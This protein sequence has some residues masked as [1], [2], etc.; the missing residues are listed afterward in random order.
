MPQSSPV[1]LFRS[2]LSGREPPTYSHHS[3]PGKPISVT[4]A[5]VP[6]CGHP[7]S[8]Q[9]K[10]SSSAVRS[11]PKLS[12]GLHRSRTSPFAQHCKSP[13]VP[14]A[15]APRAPLRSTLDDSSISEHASWRT[16]LASV[17]SKSWGDAAVIKERGQEKPQRVTFPTV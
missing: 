10:S 8:A 12:V 7:I 11:P 1:G 17:E 4:D 13:S 6:R 3:L 5:M 16:H 9:E 14:Q 15:L 2:C